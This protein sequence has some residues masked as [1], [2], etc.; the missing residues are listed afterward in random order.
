MKTPRMYDRDVQDVFV[1]EK[2]KVIVVYDAPTE[3]GI[4]TKEDLEYM[5]W[6]LGDD[7]S[8]AIENK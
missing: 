1:G 5:I 2:G 8:S 7:H 3:E 6:L 4:F